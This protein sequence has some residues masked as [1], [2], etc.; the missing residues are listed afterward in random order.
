[1]PKYGL[2]PLQ[3]NST[4]IRKYTVLKNYPFNR[5]HIIHDVPKW[6]KLW[7]GQPKFNKVKNILLF[8]KFMKRPQIKFHGHT[9]R[10]SQVIR[11]KNVKIYH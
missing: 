2:F 9:L 5:V 1:M 10:E 4:Y 11:S 3:K 8:V 7:V 6:F